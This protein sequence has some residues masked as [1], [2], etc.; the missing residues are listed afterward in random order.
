MLQTHVTP[1]AS[2]LTYS[3]A[4]KN[5]AFLTPSPKSTANNASA[6]FATLHVSLPN[7]YFSVFSGG[8][9]VVVAEHC[10]S[11]CPFTYAFLSLLPFSSF[12]HSSTPTL[13]KGALSC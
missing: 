2:M 8:F 9:V 12:K 13:V 1:A 6:C 11:K 10:L 3:T 4:G 5:P 7:Q